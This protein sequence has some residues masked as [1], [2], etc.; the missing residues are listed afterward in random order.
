MKLEKTENLKLQYVKKN[1]TN[2]TQINN[3]H[4]S[5]VGLSKKIIQILNLYEKTQ[6]L[7]QNHLST[8]GITIAEVTNLALPNVDKNSKRVKTNHKSTKN[9]INHDIN[10]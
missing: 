2:T 1:Q 7:K 3:I 10:T 8:N 9:Q 4:D 5:D 6:V